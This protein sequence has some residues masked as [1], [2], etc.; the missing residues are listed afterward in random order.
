MCTTNWTASSQ[1]LRHYCSRGCAWYFLSKN[2][3]DNDDDY[4]DD[5]KPLSIRVNR[6][7]E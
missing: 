2:D 4:E 7:L 1:R 5:Y 3:D 6:D